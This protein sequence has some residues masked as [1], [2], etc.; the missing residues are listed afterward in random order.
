MAQTIHVRFLPAL[1]PLE[2]LSARVV[3]VID[4]L[5]ATTTI[6]QALAAGAKEVVPCLEVAETREKASRCAGPV[7]LGG[8]RGGRKID[9]FDLGNSPAEY[10]PEV[11]RGKS[12]FFTT[13]NGTR[14]MHACANARRVLLGAFTNLTALCDVLQR[15]LEIELVCAGTDGQ[16]T[17]EDVL[18][19]GA[20]VGNLG[21]RLAAGIDLND[22][23]NI[24]ADAWLAC[25]KSG[26]PL[27][28]LLYASQGGQ[29]LVSIGQAADIGLAAQIDRHA[30]VPQF[31]PQEGRVV[32]AR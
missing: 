15:E 20:I 12:I 25:G 4:V 11:V 22:Q 14:T 7:L 23:A 31:L 24:A 29:N 26:V 1:L 2:S 10:T 9:G 27:E 17:R 28:V 18:L 16:I 8:E 32:L 13:T 30:V 5:R 21:A 3:V 6:V 19:A